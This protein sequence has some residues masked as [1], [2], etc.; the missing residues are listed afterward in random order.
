M[1]FGNTIAVYVEALA[2]GKV[3]PE[4]ENASLEETAE[5][6]ESTE[7]STEEAE[8]AFIVQGADRYY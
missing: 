7:A 1:I 3:N 6:F 2:D 8:G 5:T 4:T